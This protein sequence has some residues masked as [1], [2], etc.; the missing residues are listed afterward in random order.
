MASFPRLFRVALGNAKG[1]GGLAEAKAKCRF[2]SRGITKMPL[3]Y[4]AFVRRSC[5]ANGGNLTHAVHEAVS[6]DAV[7]T[8]ALRHLGALAR[9]GRLRGGGISSSSTS[10]ATKV[11]SSD[12]D[13][14]KARLKSKSRKQQKTANPRQR[15]T[16]SYDHVGGLKLAPESNDLIAAALDRA[17]NLLA[18]RQRQQ[19]Q[20]QRQQSQQK[21]SRGG[22]TTTADDVTTADM[23]AQI[24][25]IPP[26]SEVPAVLALLSAAAAANMHRTPSQRA[27]LNAFL[28]AIEDWI[29]IFARGLSAEH[30][31]SVCFW[32]ARF[33]YLPSP[34]T[35]RALSEAVLTG[36]KIDEQEAKKR[37]KQHNN[38]T[39]AA[40]T[41]T[42]SS[43]GNTDM[44]CNNSDS[45]RH[46]A[47]SAGAARPRYR[48]KVSEASFANLID[49][50]AELRVRD[51]SLSG[52]LQVYGLQYLADTR[53]QPATLA[54]IMRAFAKLGL[55]YERLGGGLL[56]T[57]DAA[58]MVATLPY[59]SAV[60]PCR[61][62]SLGAAVPAPADTMAAAAI[63][64]AAAGATRLGNNMN[65]S[66]YASVLW[67]AAIMDPE[68]DGARQLA[69][70]L[71]ERLV[72]SSGDGNGSDDENGGGGQGGCVLKDDARATHQAAGAIVAL[73]AHGYTLCDT[74]SSLLR[75]HR[76]RRNG[77]WAAKGQKTRR[78]AAPWSAFQCEVTEAMAAALA[79]VPNTRC[80]RMRTE[81]LI[82]GATAVDLAFPALRLA[83]EC[84]GPWHFIHVLG[85][86]TSSIATTTATSLAAAT[87][88]TD[89]HFPTGDSTPDNN[90]P[91]STCGAYCGA[92]IDD[93]MPAPFL[94]PP[95]LGSA[96]APGNQLHLKPE[97]VAIAS[98]SSDP[99]RCR[100][101]RLTQQSSRPPHPNKSNT[102]PSRACLLPTGTTRAKAR[103][104]RR[105]GWQ[106][107][108]LNYWDW[109][110]LSA[111]GDASTQAYLKAILLEAAA[112]NRRA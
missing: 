53:T 109:R 60:H 96:L 108:E 5:S 102:T 29:T 10:Y 17:T 25:V 13:V 89:S 110:R 104:L 48:R 47:P 11:V 38:D 42:T 100:P 1:F 63:S 7:A 55:G 65:D 18:I 68:C 16:R 52:L 32:Y 75:A 9:T 51:E 87:S 62:Y 39:F 101:P 70:G 94:P 95:P 45:S 66:Q 28:L 37:V 78:G 105:I 6:V 72:L 76:S 36:L 26:R 20:Q 50:L 77:S 15:A 97:Y 83:L 71:V 67:A 57:T 35:L 92:E 98:A 93:D 112:A 8:S 61:H 41:T 40:L 74:L 2:D 46:F 73:E 86:N 99:Y 12:V 80:G 23:V 3:L 79:D 88:T 81:Y 33:R 31:G 82:D 106:L 59:L 54:V 56:S 85:V 90:S 103:L 24:Q 64:A 111:E 14:G 58:G 91:T 22:A 44:G 34:H 49:C 84:N 69:D 30:A 19:L 4:S 107:V 27:R 21:A 43:T